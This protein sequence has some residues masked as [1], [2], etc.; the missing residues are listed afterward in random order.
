MKYNERLINSFSESEIRSVLNDPV[1]YKRLII[2]RLNRKNKDSKTRELALIDAVDHYITKMITTKPQALDKNAVIKYRDF[3]YAAYRMHPEISLDSILFKKDTI[4]L[5]FSDEQK[6]SISNYKRKTTRDVNLELDGLLKNPGQTASDELLRFAEVQIGVESDKVKN[7]VDN[8]YKYILENESVNKGYYAREFMLKYTSYNAAKDLGVPP[9]NI[10]ISDYDLDN[11][12]STSLGTNFGNTGIIKISKKTVLQ[13]ENT[14][15]GIPN[16]IS[17][18]MVVSHETRHSKQAYGAFNNVISIES[19]EY[20]K[21][22]L[23]R[24]Y[25]TTKDFDEYSRNYMHYEIESDA[26]VYGWRN[27]ENVVKKYVPSMSHLLN[28]LASNGI[29]T[30]FQESTA[31]KFNNVEKKRNSK[32]KYNVLFMD[33]IVKEHPEVLNR[34][35]LL[36]KIYLPSGERRGFLDRFKMEKSA[37]KDTSTLEKMYYDYYVNDIDNGVL[38]TLDISSLSIEMQMD[39]F[40]KL[41]FLA[42]TEIDNIKRSFK[43]YNFYSDKSDRAIQ[44]RQSEF[45]HV[46]VMRIERLKKIISYINSQNHIIERLDN[47]NKKN[48]FQKPFTIFLERLKKELVG[49]DRY[50]SKIEDLSIGEMEEMFKESM[51]LEGVEVTYGGSNK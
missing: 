24:Q 11:Q 38:D 47:E 46:N 22:R 14:H 4:G 25:L 19:F 3:L 27:A 29:I 28:K 34:F 45:R 35:P 7:F 51:S 49:M 31:S 18:L 17:L 44:L 1:L 10:Y 16:Y 33:K 50:I 48:K 36:G 13:D 23:F 15:D 40:N 12:K 6:N 39:Y 5:L 21:S 42:E 9:A 2:E 32:E 30:S 43:V 26:N 41:V 8:L 20:V 37:G